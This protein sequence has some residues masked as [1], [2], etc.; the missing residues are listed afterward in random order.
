MISLDIAESI[1]PPEILSLLHICVAECLPG[2]SYVVDRLC[3]AVHA[4]DYDTMARHLRSMGSSGVAQF[5]APAFNTALPIAVIDNRSRYAQD[6]L[7][8]GADANLRLRLD[9]S[10]LDL[11][12]FSGSRACHSLLLEHGANPNTYGQCTWF[13][14]M[15]DNHHLDDV[16]QR[17]PEVQNPH[18]PLAYAV[19][20]D[21]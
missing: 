12:I 7:I 9:F 20:L 15:M 21:R 16:L 10:M 6:L 4:D 14:P 2:P 5:Q 3:R 18:S 1:G 19:K 13:C 17:V 11:A 8:A